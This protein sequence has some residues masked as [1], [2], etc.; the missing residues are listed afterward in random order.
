MFTNLVWNTC[1]TLTHTHTHTC[2]R[3]DDVIS[4]R[5]DPG[6]ACCPPTEPVLAAVGGVDCWAVVIETAAAV[7]EAGF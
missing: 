3:T 7:F 2:A 1:N 6:V 5:E 4:A